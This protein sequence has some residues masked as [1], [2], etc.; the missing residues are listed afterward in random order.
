M[1]TSLAYVWSV[2]CLF[3]LAHAQ[4]VELP[5]AGTYNVVVIVLDDVG[6]DKLDCYTPS[7]GVLT[8]NIDK[9][10]TDGVRFTNFYSNPNCSP[11]RAAML[12]GWYGYHTGVGDPINQDCSAYTLPSAWTFL[13]EFLRDSTPS[14]GATYARGAF[15]KWHLSTYGDVPGCA[16]TYDDCHPC[17]NG[18]E[19]FEGTAGNN[20]TTSF[21]GTNSH[22]RWRKASATGGAGTGCTA[23]A[24]TAPETTWDASVTTADAL[25]WIGGLGS[26]DRFYAHIAYNPPHGPLQVPPFST[27]STST[28]NALAA[29]GTAHGVGPY[30]AGD[31]YLATDPAT[32]GATFATQKRIAFYAAALEGVDHEIGVLM[33]G[34]E[35]L[36]LLDDTMVILVSDNGTVTDLIQQPGAVDSSGAAHGKSTCFQW[37]VNVPLIVRG[38]LVPTGT[39]QVCTELVGAVDLYRTVLN[40]CGVDDASTDAESFYP[41]ILTPTGTGARSWTFFERF[42]NGTPPVTTCLQRGITDGNYKLIHTGPCLSPTS[43]RFYD[44]VADPYESTNIHAAVVAAGSG[45]AFAAYQNLD[46]ILATLQ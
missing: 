25:A 28:E 42:N 14:L 46:T 26:T 29:L 9:L 27:L 10:A 5:D 8:P 39:D 22:F 2:P 19:V 7:S 38:P 37:G 40:I 20:G 43:V 36:S 13:P 24:P 41:L 15:G 21:G 44:L 23:V 33:G 3:T 31:T 12:T 45:A 11:T 1:A 30:V 32:I 4:D 18:F 34:L 16:L 17:D 6:R 35:S